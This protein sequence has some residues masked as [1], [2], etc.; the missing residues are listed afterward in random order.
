MLRDRSLD[1]LDAMNVARAT[2][3]VMAAKHA[4]TIVPGYT[5][6][7]Q[8][9]P[10]TFGHCLLGFAGAFDRDA[11]RLRQAYARLDLNPLG[12]AVYGTS[13]F[14]VNRVRLA[15]LLGFDGNVENGYDE[16]RK[17]RRWT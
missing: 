6:G 5:N 11:D 10:T 2:L 14:P 15:E 16:S 9:Q 7:V 13:S 8:A 4:G 12:V 17:S 1:L 3:L